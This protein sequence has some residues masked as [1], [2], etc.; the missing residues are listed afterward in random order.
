MVLTH[1]PPFLNTLDEEIYAPTSPIWD[2]EFKQMPALHPHTLLD[3][4]T[5]KSM[6]KLFTCLKCRVPKNSNKNVYVHAMLFL[7]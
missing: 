7:H 4:N 2:P 1:F 3:T 5:S 6:F